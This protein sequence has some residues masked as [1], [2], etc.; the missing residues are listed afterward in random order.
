V[1]VITTVQEEHLEGFG[2]LAGVLAEELSLC[3]E[4]PLA[5]VPDSE[6]DVIAAARS[7]AGRVVT[8][9]LNGGDRTARAHGLDP[10][11]RGWMEWRGAHVAVPLPGEHNLRNAALAVAV[12]DEFGVSVRDAAAGIA[13]MH[14]PAMRSD[15]GALGRALLVHDAYNSNPGSARAAIALLRAVG[16]ERQ[17]VA[18]LGTMGELGASAER[19]HREVAEVALSSGADIVCGI[20][21]FAATL[22]ALAPGD[23]R[24]ITAPDVEELWPL[25]RPRLRSD[26]A[27]LLKASRSVRLERLV[28]LLNT[29]ATS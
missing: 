7:R 17:R 11:G 3:D 6:P 4:A 15:V 20:G 28:P 19:A 12:A 16:A 13:R 9:G 26:A 14:P 25:L 5:I 2:D 27:I 23:E 22:D 8:A 1:V 10:D 29:W 18:V 21:L 24:V